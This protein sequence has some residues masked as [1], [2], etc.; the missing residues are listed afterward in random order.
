[1]K[2]K[3]KYPSRSTYRLFLFGCILRF[4]PDRFFLKRQY[5]RRTGQKLNLDQPRTVNE[6]MQWLKLH[7]RRPEYIRMADKYEVRN[8][9]SKIIGKEYLVPLLGVWER[10]EDI[11]FS[12]LPDQFVLKCTHDAGG[13]VIC[14][15]KSSLDI[16]AARQKINKS[17]KTNYYWLFR[18][19]QYKDIL[20]RIIAEP[21][22]TDESGI[23]LK[24]YKVHCFSGKPGCIGVDL[25]RFS[26]HHRNI[27]DPNW[28]LMDM[29]IRRPISKEA[30][31]PRPER[32]AEMLKIAETLAQGQPYIR[33]DFYSIR[34]KLYF[35]ELTFFHGAGYEEWKPRAYAEM[36]G[37]RID[38]S[39]LDS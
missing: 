9:V 18:E 2:N 34:D 37:D 13:L 24:D 36:F 14:K 28:N 16:S 33:V 15:D 11:D 22:M 7:N 4:I 21:Y 19:W 31:I 6:K 26:I 32:F 3:Q 12:V 23:E 8:Y 17:L 25:G 20:P 30:H 27:Y 38:L 10:F 29:Q 39:L 35:G 1:M 5:L